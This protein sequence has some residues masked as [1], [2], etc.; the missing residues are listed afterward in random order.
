MVASFADG[1]KISFEQAIVANATGMTIAQRG[2]NGFDFT[3][4]KDD[5]IKRFNMDYTGHVDDLT[6]V[7]DIDQL[8]EKRGIVDYVVG[9]KPPPGVFVIAA[10][11]DTVQQQYLGYYKMGSGPLYTFYTP[12]HICHFDFPLSIARIGI[13]KDPVITPTFGPRVDVIALAKC[14]LKAGITLDGLGGFH[15]YGQCETYD[16]TVTGSL[17][18]IGLAEGCMMI[19]DVPKDSPL[20]YA[21]V[22]LPEG[23]L[24]DKLREEQIRHFPVGHDAGR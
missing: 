6:Q 13:G 21:D 7:Y 16:N 4:D 5:L 15:T 10:K 18:P 24:C 3:R 1:T 9:L 23:R 11:E 22:K 2:M 17:L 8:R 20:T 12:M 14:D 19:R